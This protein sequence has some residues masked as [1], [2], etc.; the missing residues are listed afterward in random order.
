M[1]HRNTNTVAGEKFLYTK[2]ANFHKLNSRPFM[3]YA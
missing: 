3:E 2:G 1:R